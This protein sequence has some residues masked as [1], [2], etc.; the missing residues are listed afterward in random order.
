MEV[1]FY[2]SAGGENY[3]GSFIDSLLDKKA[4]KKII[5]RLESVEEHGISILTHS[6]TM[7]KIHNYRN[8]IFEIKIDFNNVFYRITYVIR[9]GTCWL[10]SIFAKKDNKTPLQQI[11]TALQRA[12]DLDLSLGLALN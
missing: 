3:V 2:C 7:R 6:G 4:A 5:R 11:R 1:E 9:A 10:L 12:K 8:G